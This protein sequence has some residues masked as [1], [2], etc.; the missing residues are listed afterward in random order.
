M[1]S[2]ELMKFLIEYQKDESVAKSEKKDFGS[3]R[4]YTDAIF[5]KRPVVIPVPVHFD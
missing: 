5:M 4:K 2:P 3:N 1:Y